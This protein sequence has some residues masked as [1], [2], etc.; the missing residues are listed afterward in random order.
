MKQISAKGNVTYY[1]SRQLARGEKGLCAE[2][3]KN[4][5]MLTSLFFEV[6]NASTRNVARRLGRASKATRLQRNESSLV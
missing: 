5:A 1:I 4:T 6:K 3:H 2:D